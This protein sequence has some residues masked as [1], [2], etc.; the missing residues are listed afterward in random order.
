M[1]IHMTIK[2]RAFENKCSINKS[3][4][5]SKSYALKEKIEVM[6]DEKAKV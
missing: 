1:T 6:C 3:L 2:S 4:I 5:N